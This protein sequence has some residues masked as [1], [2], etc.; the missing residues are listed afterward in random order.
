MMLPILWMVLANAASFLGAWAILSRIRTNRESLDVLLLILIR[1]ALISATIL[2]AGLL[3][4]MTSTG[5]GIVATIVLTL[6]L[7][8]GIRPDRESFRW[9]A[10]GGPAAVFTAVVSLRLLLQAWFFAPYAG[11]TLCYHLP[12]VAEWTRAGAITWETGANW[13]SAFPA[14]FELVELW[15]VVFLHHDAIIE[16]AGLE[17]LALS[18]S[19]MYVLAREFQ[20]GERTSYAAALL[21]TMTPGIHLQATSC[22]NDGPTAA[23]WVAAAALVIAR[24]PL[25]LVILPVG[26]GLGVKP[27]YGYALPGL[28]LLWFLWRRPKPSSL[29]PSRWL[30]FLCL[31]GLFLGGFWYGRNAVRFGN[32]LHPMGSQ[33]MFNPQGRMI[34]QAG[35]SLRSLMEN[36]RRLIDSRIHDPA[37]LTAN[38]D[39]SSGWGI[40]LFALGLPAMLMMGADDPRFRRLSA[41]FSLSL[42][43]VLLLVYSDPWFARFVLFFA[44]FP[45]LS[46]AA[47]M[48]KMRPVRILAGASLV[49]LF[50]QGTMPADMPWEGFRSMV[51]QPWVK[52]QVPLL[53]PVLRGNE[54]VLCLPSARMPYLLYGPD[55]SRR[56]LYARPE[57]AA[58]L[59]SIMDRENVRV[60]YSQPDPILDEGVKSGWLAR[61]WG[62]FYERR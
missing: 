24:A 29:T 20:L 2:A 25:S 43:S 35:P 56:V 47:L 26:M 18:F 17:F 11:D 13:R 41:G 37:L 19:A 12:K 62:H 3:G 23:L 50:F 32:P 30:V 48:E 54:P 58:D 51:C 60:V 38:L 53:P 8:A 31:L 39:F 9:P 1:L 33:G 22:F 40:G 59:K 57:N 42:A 6:L 27:T 44:A 15:W 45:A 34:Q 14:G 21:F 16:M 55:F 5:L 46:A 10:C 28:I 36:A 52:R 4:F 49:F 61:G 7:A